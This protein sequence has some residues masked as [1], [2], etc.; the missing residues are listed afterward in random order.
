MRAIW[1]LVVIAAIAVAFAVGHV[2]GGGGLAPL[3]RP[4]ES[5]LR[6]WLSA[7]SG[8]AAVLAAIATILYLHAQVRDADR[9]QRTGFAIQLRKQRILAARTA[10][11]AYIVLD[12]IDKQEKSQGELGMPTWDRETVEGMVHQLRDV[13]ISAFESEI[14]HPMSVGGWAMAMIVEKGYSGIEPAV[15]TAPGITRTYFENLRDQ[16]EAFLAEVKEITQP[17]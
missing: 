7:T 14:A 3:C 16:A 10:R 13:T 17:R 6:E 11:V 12:E 15:R 8:W 5:C 2:L 4:D 9:H 1:V